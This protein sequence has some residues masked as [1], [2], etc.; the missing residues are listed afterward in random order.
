[1]SRRRRRRH[2][3][4]AW[5]SAASDARDASAPTRPA[6]NAASACQRCASESLPRAKWIACFQQRGQVAGQRLFAAIVG[7]EQH[8]GQ[9]W[10]RAEREHPPAQCGDRSAVERAQ[11]LQQLAR[12]GERSRRRCVDEAQ[13][14]V[15]PRGQFQCEAGEFDL[16]D[17]RAALRLQALR[18]RPQPVRPSLRD[19]AGAAGALVGRGLRDVD[20]VQAREATVGVVA[21][22]AREPG[23][24]HHAHAGE[25]HA[26]FGDVGGEHDAAAA[27]RIRLQHAALLFDGELAVQGEHVDARERAGGVAAAGSGPQQRFHARDLA[28]PG[29]EH[30]HVARMLCQHLL[31]RASRLVFQRF[32]A[33]CGKVR[34]RHGEAAS[35]T[36]QPRRVEETGQPLAVERGRHHHDAQV[37]AQPGLHVQ[38]QRQAQVGRQVPLMEFVEQ[39]RADAFQHRIVLQHAGEDAFGD[40]F[41]PCRRADACSRSGCDSRRC[42]RPLRRAGVP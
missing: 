34:D 40:D 17:F 42:R 20:H 29:Q 2:C 23:V 19:A 22:L 16:C 37:L 10:M 6:R 38:R 4:A 27:V 32:V 21:R 14:G 7:R 13:V 28:L 11:A 39:Q 26:G 35:G 41:D 24:D 18:F 3:L 36:A 12:G 33:A 30:Q 25:R 9:T 1:M 5:S 8:R 15:A 31:H